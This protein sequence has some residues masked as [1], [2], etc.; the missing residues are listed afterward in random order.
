[1]Q[2][3][4]LFWGYLAYTYLKTLPKITQRSKTSITRGAILYFSY[5]SKGYTKT[6]MSLIHA[7][8][9][10]IPFLFL[11]Y[12][13][14]LKFL[15]KT[16]VFLKTHKNKQKKNMSLT[17][18]N[19]VFLFSLFVYLFSLFLNRVYLSY[20]ILFSF[21]QFKNFTKNNYSLYFLYK[22]FNNMSP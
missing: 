10:Y 2:W 18:S 8:M 1:M 13:I 17:A 5:F 20:N 21:T 7:C 12:I 11:V 6:C 19:I 16:Q 3:F 22:F 4:N 14:L 9:L 15:V